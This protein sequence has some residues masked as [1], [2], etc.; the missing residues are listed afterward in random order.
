MQ[1]LDLLVLDQLQLLLL[2]GQ[3]CSLKEETIT[4]NRHETFTMQFKMLRNH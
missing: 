4:F 3:R 2:V 1:L